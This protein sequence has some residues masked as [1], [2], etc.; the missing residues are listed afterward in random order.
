M[1]SICKRGDLNEDL[2]KEMKVLHGIR[3]LRLNSGVEIQES[4][5]GEVIPL[6][7]AQWG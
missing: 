3:H 7:E 2:A 6:K 4:K 1:G 5:R